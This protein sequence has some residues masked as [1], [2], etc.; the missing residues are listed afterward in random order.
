MRGCEVAAFALSRCARQKRPGGLI[1]PGLF[2]NQE[3]GAAL[4][5]LPGDGL[6]DRLI[7]IASGVS[8]V[9]GRVAKPKGIPPLAHTPGLHP[10]MPA[11]EFPIALPPICVQP[12]ALL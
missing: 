3:T 5:N 4:G 9:P 8:L 1:A 11:Q 2:C 12:T 7:R 6:L 10:A